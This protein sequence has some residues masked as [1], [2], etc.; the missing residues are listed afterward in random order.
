[1]ALLQT[2][3][4]QKPGRLVLVPQLLV[5]LIIW[6]NSAA[7]QQ[8]R[9]RFHP[10]P[11]EAVQFLEPRA[12]GGYVA[13]VGSGG[14]REGVR[15]ILVS[16]DFTDVDQYWQTDGIILGDG[17][18]TKAILRLDPSG[19][20]ISRVEIGG[21]R[22][23]VQAIGLVQLRDGS[24]VVAGT[25]HTPE[26]ELVRPLF[27]GITVTVS[28]EPSMESWGFV[29]KTDSS[30][31]RIETATLIGG[32]GRG[33]GE[34]TRVLDLA[35]DVQG[36]IYLSGST[37]HQDFPVT[38]SAWRRV[39]NLREMDGESGRTLSEGFL[40]KLSPDLGSLLASTLLAAETPNCLPAGSGPCQTRGV[41][42]AAVRLTIS[43]QGD[44]VVLLATTGNDFPVT[45][46][47]YR[48]P[49]E[50]ESSG[51]GVGQRLYLATFSPDLARLIASSHVSTGE[52]IA[53]FANGRLRLLARPDGT[54]LTLHTEIELSGI[55]IG[56][57]RQTDILTLWNREG[58]AI[59]GDLRFATRGNEAASVSV[60]DVRNGL[61]GSVWAAGIANRERLKIAGTEPAID[62][63]TRWNSFLLKLR[64]PGLT[65]ERVDR[66]P[67]GA[68][69][70]IASVSVT[71][72]NVLDQSGRV[73]QYPTKGIGSPVIL[74][75]ADM[76]GPSGSL[77]PGMA[78]M[79][80]VRLM[81]AGFGP[82]DDVHGFFDRNGFLSTMLEG[83]RV[84]VNGTV[85]PL[86]S[87]GPHFIDF[88]VPAAAADALTEG[89][90]EAIVKLS[91]A[92]G[93]DLEYAQEVAPFWLRPFGLAVQDESGDSSFMGSVLNEDGAVNSPSSPALPG[94]VLT[95]YL[96]GPGLPSGTVPDGK[97]M[98]TA[99]PWFEAQPLLTVTQPLSELEPVRRAAGETLY[100]GAAPGL[101]AGTIQMNFRIPKA[102]LDEREFLAGNSLPVTVS[103]NLPVRGEAGE[104]AFRHAANL[105]IWIQR[106]AGEDGQP[107]DAR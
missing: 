16:G 10:K 65:G 29:L 18:A 50:D 35:R 46:G 93:L 5:L 11:G 54:L 97:R 81:G 67:L 38:D 76:A 89:S 56:D 98:D 52:R 58:T 14:S 73:R 95:A 23:R 57:F 84:T 85:A 31:R 37:T 96:N 60:V 42:N 86:L 64:G 3:F 53:P 71:G 62:V 102:A 6:L 2:P 1:M 7:A 39:S 51:Y 45:A 82:T 94:E 36:N 20:E 101:A 99:R 59:L 32:R 66:L 25:A 21:D 30:L 87:V 61:D 63:P 33:T 28:E 8:P 40:M 4:L 72:V 49:V 103:V 47:A 17:A 107:C 68:A 34:G 70:G 41:A 48:P 74:G 15:A 44:P 27:P 79:Q 92:G 83:L 43:R 80:F 55:G 9:F 13:V 19:T 24:V 88:I 91:S 22:R 106:C 90:R 69:A 12:Q 78:P 105:A 104:V 100:F 75:I 77:L 26:F